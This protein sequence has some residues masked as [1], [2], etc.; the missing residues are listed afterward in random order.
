MSRL[1]GRACFASRNS[2]GSRG[3]LR[4][5]RWGLSSGICVVVVALALLAGSSR[6]FAS[7]PEPLANSTGE[8]VGGFGAP[9]FEL[10]DVS[11]WTLRAGELELGPTAVRYGIAGLFQIGSRFA[12]NLFGAINAD[13]KWTIYS[14]AR[15]GIGVDAGLLRF[16]PALVGIDDDFAVW[17]FPVAL[18]ASGR[19]NEHLRLHAAI[20]FLSAKATADASDV[21]KRVERYVGPVAKLAARLGAEWRFGDHVALLAELETPLILHVSTFRYANEDAATDFMRG[22]LALQ[23]VYDSLNVRLGAGYGPSFLGRSGLFPIFELMLR[24]Y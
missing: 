3:A 17:A 13:A 1:L 4:P 19:P 7:E 9:H 23:L 15:L 14:T 10:T 5:A 6:A 8:Q 2:S 20:E 24:L 18:R 21:V 12:L 22:K 16:D 11:A